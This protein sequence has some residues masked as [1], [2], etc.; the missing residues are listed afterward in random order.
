MAEVKVRGALRQLEHNLQSAAQP[1]ALKVGSPDE[2]TE[3][4]FVNAVSREHRLSV[5]T[6]EV[7]S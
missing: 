1:L 5:T 2:V 3:C 7:K 6:A 4:L